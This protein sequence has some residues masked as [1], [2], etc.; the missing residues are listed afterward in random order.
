MGGYPFYRRVDR[1]NAGKLLMISKAGGPVAHSVG[2][3]TPG[4]GVLGSIPAV[5]ARSLLVGSVSV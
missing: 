1:G 3:A 5:A 4:Q 2:R